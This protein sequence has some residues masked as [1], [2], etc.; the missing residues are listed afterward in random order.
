MLSRRQVLARLAALPAAPLLAVLEGDET[1]ICEGTGYSAVLT[2]RG[3]RLCERNGY[4]VVLRFDGE[5]VRFQGNRWTI[6]ESS[7]RAVLSEGTGYSAVATNRDG[8]V[9]EGTGYGAL[10]TMRQSGD[11]GRICPRT[12]S[13]AEWTARGPALTDGQVL[14]TLLAL[15]ALP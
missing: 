3:D 9:T 13:S 7:S 11:T 15:D 5:R 8:R 6:R 10:W 14:A 12:S 4:S 2:W 1:R